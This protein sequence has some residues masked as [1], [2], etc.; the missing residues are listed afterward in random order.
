MGTAA[1][2]EESVSS[3]RG[4]RRTGTSSFGDPCK[5]QSYFHYKPQGWNNFRCSDRNAPVPAGAT[6]VRECT[7]AVEEE[8]VSSNR[9]Y[10]RTGT[11]SF[12]DPC[13]CQSYFHY[14]PQGWNNFRCSDRH[15]PVPAGATGVRECTAALEEQST[16]AK[17]NR[18]LRKA[19]EATLE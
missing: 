12:G 1:V 17:V 14:K 13:K 16:L 5:C 4:Y 6:G 15:A 2:E 19:L 11:S 7:A 10:R 9:G 8:S 18:A 3:N